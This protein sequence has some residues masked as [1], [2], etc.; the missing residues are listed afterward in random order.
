MVPTNRSRQHPQRNVRGVYM[1]VCTIWIPQCWE[2]ESHWFNTEPASCLA[3]TNDYCLHCF[4]L[5]ELRLEQLKY[6]GYSTKLPAS[7]ISSSQQMRKGRWHFCKYSSE[8]ESKCSMTHCLSGLPVLILQ[9]AVICAYSQTLKMKTNK[10]KRF[11]VRMGNSS[12]FL[13]DP[14]PS[15]IKANISS[16]NASIKSFLLLLLFLNIKELI[17]AI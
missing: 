4:K 10:Q 11:K 7:F 13:C 2:Q 1:C 6:S 14:I 8:R 12:H 9:K 5:N 3:W 16:S 17:M 15:S